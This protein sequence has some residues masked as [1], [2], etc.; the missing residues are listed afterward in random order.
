MKF[1]IKNL[2][3]WVVLLSVVSEV[4]RKYSFIRILQLWQIVV[5]VLF[6]INNL[7]VIAL[8]VILLQPVIFSFVLTKHSKLMIWL[9]N[10]IV[11]VLISMYKNFIA[12]EEFFI[13]FKLKEQAA[14]ITIITIFWMNL[15]CVSYG[16]DLIDSKG[17]QD[18]VAFLSYCLYLP[19]ALTGPFISYKDFVTSHKH[20]NNLFSRLSQLF[21][22]VSRFLFWLFFTELCLHFIY[23]NATGFH[24]EWV[25]SLDSWSLYGYG[26]TMGQFFHIKYLVIYGLATSFAKFENIKVPSLPVCIG[27]IHLYS[28]MWKYFDAGLYN[29]LLRYIYI[30]TM[31]N[32]FITSRSLSSL[33]CFL[34]VYVWHGTDNY[35]L[36]WTL[37]NY[38]G[39]IIENCSHWFNTKYLQNSKLYES[40]GP[41]WF[42]RINCMTASPLLAMSA[43]S[44]FYFF[45]RIEI[46]NIFFSRFMNDNSWSNFV[47]LTILYNCCQVSTEVRRKQRNSKDKNA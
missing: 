8:L 44:N 41:K 14:Y 21:L 5:T 42:R 3:L 15:R 20:S 47:L 38:I 1:L 34:F 45:A 6:I 27:R 32:R 36:I 13:I 30:P 29:F 18:F 25:E 33:F 4:L 24:P 35:I 46:G 17:K 28:D 40:L 7:G 22:D 39:V 43:I 2:C 31:K 9:C 11:L 37:L 10:G 23:V 12:K 19:N 26:Y 16:L